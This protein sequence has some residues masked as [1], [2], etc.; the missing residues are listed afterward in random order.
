ALGMTMRR[1]G[2]LAGAGP[3]ARVELAELRSS[4]G[5]YLFIPLLLLQTIGTAL[6]EVGF[7]DTSLLITPAAFAVRSMGTL[8][9]CLCLLLLFYTVESLE[10]E[11]STRLAAIAHA[12]PIRTGSILLGKVMAL[13]VVALVVVLAVALGGIIAMMVQGKVGLSLRPFLV[14]W[15]LLLAPTIRVWIAFVAAVHTLTQSRYATYA[16]ALAV[17][18]FTGYRLLTNQV[19]WLGN[20]PLW[21]AVRP[22][23]MSV[24]EL[25]RRALVLSRLLAVGSAVCS[26]FLTARS[27]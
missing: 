6:I 14:Y 2:L 7:L 3:V 19:N 23:D 18:F 9:T 11:R 8:A 22:S 17:L 27:F 12:T 4:P 1:P 10:R 20:W 21:D 5:L 16:I 13:G 26:G 25:D 24:L 15:G